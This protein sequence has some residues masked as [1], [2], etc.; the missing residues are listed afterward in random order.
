MESY[1]INLIKIIAEPKANSS[2]KFVC[3]MSLDKH[4]A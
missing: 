2:R 4:R 1:D 3:V